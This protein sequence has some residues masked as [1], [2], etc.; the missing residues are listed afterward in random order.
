MSSRYPS[1][2]KIGKRERRAI[3]V[4]Q[5]G[6]YFR[7]AL[8]TQFYP[9]RREQFVTRLYDANRRVVPGFGYATLQR[10]RDVGTVRRR[11]CPVGST[12]PSEYVIA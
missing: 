12:F 4:L 10:L 5:Q 2:A 3:E 6:G 1:F 7:H 8:E 11:D 9:A